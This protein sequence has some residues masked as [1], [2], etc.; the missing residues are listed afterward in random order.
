MELKVIVIKLE[1]TFSPLDEALIYHLTKQDCTRSS[2]FNVNSFR[3]WTITYH[4]PRSVDYIVK[5]VQKITKNQI[6]ALRKLF[7]GTKTNL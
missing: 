5:L 6:L 7:H 1:I 2:S 4:E 3:I